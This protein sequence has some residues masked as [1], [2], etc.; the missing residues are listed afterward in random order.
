MDRMV[1]DSFKSF[2][3]QVLIILIFLFIGWQITPYNSHFIGAKVGLII[4]FYCMWL[5]KKRIERLL[6]NVVKGKKTISLGLFNRAAAVILGAMIMYEYGHHM[7]M[8]AFA[9]GILGG[10]FL[11]VINL[12]YYS[13]LSAKH[14]EIDKKSN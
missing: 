11:F 10:Y 12:M 14:E 4:S 9:T 8:W 2:R 1:I 3:K 7:A 5:L 6:D 13:H